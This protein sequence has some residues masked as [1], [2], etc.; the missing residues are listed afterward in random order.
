MNTKSFGK[1]SKSIIDEAHSY[2][3]KVP[4]GAGGKKDCA[5]ASELMTVYEKTAFSMLPCGPL[6][7]FLIRLK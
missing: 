4:D 3:T 7:E 5:P 6:N 2:S 1:T